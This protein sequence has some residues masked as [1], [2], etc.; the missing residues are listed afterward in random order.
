MLTILTQEMRKKQFRIF[1]LLFVL[2]SF[3][4]AQTTG[5][6]KDSDGFPEADVE[7]KIKGTDKAAFTDENGDFNIDAK[8]GDILIIKGKEITVTSEN[9]G[10]LSTQLNPKNENID[11]GTAVVTGYSTQRKEEVTAAVSVVSSKDLV[12]TKSPNITN[13]L[14][15]KVAG[16]RITSGSGRP[17]ATASMRLRGR[18]SISAGTDALWVVDGVIYHGTPN[19][20][21]NDVETV[22]V[23]KDAAATA[24]YG[25]RGAN[26]VLVIT[27]KRGRSKGL[28]VG[29]DYS[30][31]WN[32]FNPGKFKV[33]NS[34]QMYDTFMAMS[35][36]PT[37]QV[38]PKE[39]ATQN[40]DWVENGTQIG[41][42]TDANVS[43]SSNTES[44]N[45]FS[46]IGYY[47]EDGTVKGYDYERLSARLN[48]DQ[49]L[50]DR[51]SFK[52]KLNA[53]FTNTES[54]EHSLYG[55][56]TNMPW[57]NPFYA[58][59]SAVAPVDDTNSGK[60]TKWYGRDQSNYYYNLK[61][62]Y[63]KTELFDIQANLDLAWKI[64]NSLT[65]ES[66]N[67][68]QYYSSTGMSYNDPKAIGATTYSGS[69]YQSSVRRIVRLF[70]QMLRYQ[71]EFGLHKLSGYA[72]YEY[73]DYEYQDLTG[74]KRGIIPG[75]EILNNGANPYAANGTKND[76]AFQAGLAQV[77]Y[78]YDNRYNF[79]A[80][81]RLD[82]SSRFGKNNRYAHFYAFSAGWNISNE[83]FLKDSKV[84]S[85]L[86]LRGSYGIVG[87]AGGTDGAY[88]RQYGL[89]GLSGQYN[90]QPAVIQGQYR[91]PDVT[92][93][94][95][96]D[97]N[98]GLELGLFNRINMTLDVYDKYTDDLLT[99]IPFLASSGWTNYWDNVGALSNKG[100][101]FSINADI[102]PRSSEFQWNIG[103]NI[104]SNKNRVE[105]L[106]NDT[107][108]NGGAIVVGKDVNTWYMRKW[109]G[110]DPAT[111]NPLW[112]HVDAKT[113]EVTAKS[114]YNNATLQH[115]GSSNPNYSGGFNTSMSYKGFV[116][117]ADFVYSKGGV[118]YNAGRE[119]FDADG[120]YPYYNQMVLQNGWSR[121]TPDN[122]NATHPKLAY[123][124][125]SNSNK[126][127]S[128]YL[129]DASFLRM[130]NIRLAYNFDQKNI[131]SLGL[132][133]LTLYVSGDNLWTATKYT[134]AD[135]EAVISGDTTSNYPNPKRYTFGVNLNF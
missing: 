101:E 45:L 62:N 107:P 66:T 131:E 10:D 125:T 40:F 128:R 118:A 70:N 59:G 94:Q 78:G 50:S 36:L 13:L 8:I 86:K 108:M 117:A 119:F 11:L 92:W 20:N 46:T 132:K 76:Y 3:A 24:Q 114:D 64:S 55:M 6:V 19:I 41:K 111:G 31:S 26:G 60:L 4:Y 73:S 113:G 44:T 34:Q 129:E 100:I 71:R 1:S 95:T 48:L 88:Y 29:V 18:S 85:N 133:G 123:N 90:G 67:N 87:N 22:S 12:D 89:Y 61:T 82:G 35:N 17:G 2:G 83:A 69:I 127:S 84:I 28:S 112:E 9:L 65:F 49:K 58:D 130:R 77:N 47:K 5:H 97:A 21:P 56:Y 33:M 15:G 93:E 32:F 124:N 104:A 80:S 57:D 54:R 63:G 109:A 16:L 23:L 51:L 39:L 110:V 126:T 37:S 68:V 75:A 74:T 52:P 121:W 79:Q 72:A 7:V 38:P 135:I 103:F 53:T 122:P 105:K 42:V 116:L 134:G 120:A 96:R 91:N 102:F 25:S 106:Y 14:Q 99:S 43:I 81:Y 27:T 30:N 115:L 98:I